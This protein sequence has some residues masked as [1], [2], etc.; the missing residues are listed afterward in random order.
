MNKLCYISLA[1]GVSLSL[2]AEET[3]VEVEPGKVDI[4]TTNTH[5]HVNE[6]VINIDSDGTTVFMDSSEPAKI[7]VGTPKCKVSVDNTKIKISTPGGKKKAKLVEIETE[8]LAK[9]QVEVPEVAASKVAASEPLLMA[10][11]KA[12]SCEPLLDCL[13]DECVPEDPSDKIIPVRLKKIRI[14]PAL[15]TGSSLGEAIEISPDICGIDEADLRC[16]LEPFLC[17]KIRCRDFEKI[18]AIVAGAFD[19]RKVPYTSVIIPP[20]DISDGTLQVVVIQATVGNVCVIGNKWN[21]VDSVLKH[22]AIN[23]ECPLYLQQLESN[24]A[25]YNRN[26]FLRVDAVLKPG[27]R[28]GMTDIDLVVKDRIPFRPY[29]GGDNTGVQFTSRGRWYAGFS[30]GRIWGLDHLM[31][32]QF[33]TSDNATSFLGYSGNYSIP[34]PWRHNFVAF[35]GWARVKGDLPMP[36]LTNHGTSWQVSGRYQVPLP[37]I[38]GK[39]LQEVYCGYDFKRTNNTLIFGGD[40]VSNQA[41]DINQFMLGYMLDYHSRASKSSVVAEIYGAPF[42]M[43]PFQTKQRYEALRFDAKPLY[44]Y[45]H[46]RLSHTRDIIANFEVMANLTGQGTGWNLLP[47]EELGIGGYNS[48]RG[49][50]ERA[51]NTDSG[52][53]ASLEVRTPRTA[54][55]KLGKRGA[56]KEIFQLLAFVDYGLGI[57]SVPDPGTSKTDW[58]LGMGGGARYTYSSN[59][60]LRCDIGVPFHRTGTGRYGTHIHAGGT[61]SY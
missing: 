59:I 60:A 46:V 45:G 27:E 8:D 26:P 20:Q 51:L 53:L 2:A 43:T 47:S 49:Y 42:K 24:L 41:A 44:C 34:L 14:A 6:D 57:F 48:V 5:V 40:E 61:L 10:V 37:L 16:D 21:S 55:F 19:D 31:S 4:D 23:C 3:Q 56:E 30:A 9:T 22:A 58:L 1:I 35:G 54:V 36:G 18:R 15:T 32:F 12:S 11:S 13:E 38:F 52:L 25:W 50:E 7:S 17:G 29:V 33:T 28:V 39:M